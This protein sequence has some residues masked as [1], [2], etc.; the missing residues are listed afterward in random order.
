MLAKILFFASSYAILLLI[1][2]NRTIPSTPQQA[3]E[4]KVNTTHNN[5]WKWQYKDI[6]NN[7]FG[8]GCKHSFE[9]YVSGESNI[10]VNN[11]DQLCDWLATCDYV[12][13]IIKHGKHDY[14][15]HPDDFERERSGDCED[16]A[17]WAW[18]K[19][20]QMNLSAEFMVGKLIQPDGRIENHAWLM[21][22]EN[23]NR[24]ILETTAK[25]KQ[26][27]LK[28]FEQYHPYYLPFAAVTAEFRKKA[29]TSLIARLGRYNRSLES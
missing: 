17:L 23:D 24:I 16:F 27:M 22:I 11:L 26:T 2:L 8:P 18:R 6:P 7:F 15:T 13:D 21:L 12:A 14:W 28:P 1:N 25:N 10:D 29:Y 20:K 19:L 5:L 3:S 9:H 4:K